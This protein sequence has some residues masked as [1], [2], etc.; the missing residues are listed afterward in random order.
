[1]FVKWFFN[2]FNFYNLLVEFNIDFEVFVIDKGIV[3][4]WIFNIFK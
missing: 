2:M 1:M 4:Y 3:I